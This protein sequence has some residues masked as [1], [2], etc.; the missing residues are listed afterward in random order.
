MN[1]ISPHNT[2][3][4]DAPLSK[5]CFSTPNKYPNL[6]DAW[7]EK[8]VDVLTPLN[9]GYL[10]YKTRVQLSDFEAFYYE[11]DIDAYYRHEASSHETPAIR[12]LEHYLNQN[13][14]KEINQ[15]K[16]I[17]CLQHV[18]Y[19]ME[20]VNLARE[21]THLI[22][23][24]STITQ[25]TT[26]YR[27]PPSL[28]SEILEQIKILK[29][30]SLNKDTLLYEHDYA[31]YF[32][33]IDLDNNWKEVAKFLG[34]D[35]KEI[36]HIESLASQDKLVSMGVWSITRFMLVNWTKSEGNKA[37]IDLLMYALY[38]SG[39][40]EVA[41]ELVRLKRYTPH[42]IMQTLFPIVTSKNLPIHRKMMCDDSSN[43]YVYKLVNHM[44]LS[45]LAPL[46]ND[47]NR[48][49]KFAKII[50][51]S[52]D[53][54][55]FYVDE[56]K[57]DHHNILRYFPKIIGSSSIKYTSNLVIY[58]LCH[59]DCL[60]LAYHYKQQIIRLNGSF[61][62]HP[63]FP[64]IPEPSQKLSTPL[65]ASDLKSD[66]IS[67]VI[68]IS[69]PIIAKLECPVCYES[70]EM[71]EKNWFALSC[72]HMFCSSCLP[73]IVN[74]FKCCSMCNNP[75]TVN[76]KPYEIRFPDLKFKIG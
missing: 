37:T 16:L 13:H 30:S 22:P 46:S 48:L 10:C 58:A 66:T 31:Q 59:S 65:P 43:G 40:P 17:L 36:E 26:L 55:E 50:G 34:Y 24:D 28:T 19:K 62:N 68:A 53:E 51:Y 5:K 21:L 35:S 67:T 18:L 39:Y 29:E 6:P 41:I 42:H 14:K 74:I 15:S 72:S 27:T 73:K 54:L 44:D 71:K 3:N 11:L 7:L 70:L 45:F 12:L 47:M 8:V 9:K 38:Q 20:R 56:V 63:L 69:M 57:E 32:V 4:K 1:P 60:E 61:K 52:G 75:I 23:V 2:C 25:D 64:P 49:I 76:N 33:S